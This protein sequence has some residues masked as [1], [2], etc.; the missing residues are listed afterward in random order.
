MRRISFGVLLIAFSTLV[1]EVMLTR[2]FDVTLAP[3]VSYFVVTLAVFSFGL[4]G[5]YATLRPIPVEQ[6]IRRILRTRSFAFAVT[7]LLLVPVI[8]ALPLDYTHLGHHPVSIL[9]AF[10]TLYVVLLLPFFLAGYILIAVFSKYAASIQR[11]YFWD[12]IGAGLGTVLVIPLIAKIGPGGLIVCAAAVALLAAALFSERRFW[13]QAAVVA[14]IVVAAIPFLRAPNYIDFDQHMDKRGVMTDL[15]AGLGEFVRWDPIAKI[16]VIDQ[17][18]T[19]QKAASWWPF[20]DRKVIQYDGG[21]QSSYFFPFDGD[22]KKFRAYIDHDKSHVKAHFWQIGVLASHYLKRDSG[23]SVLIIGSAGG[24]ETKAAL[25]Y[26]AA[27][28]DAVELVPTVVELAT[29]QYSHY[30]GDIFHNPAVHAVAG[31][32]RSYLRHSDRLYDIIQMY[33]N[34][35]NSS[36][37]QGTGA[38]SPEYLQTAEAY[39]EYFSHLTPNGVLHI[40]HSAF[41]RMI[42]TAALA[43]KRMG[44]TDFERHVAVYT[45]DAEPF[46][47]TMLIKMQPWT[48]AEI[49]DLNSFLAPPELGARYWQHLVENPLDPSKSFLSADF[50][51]GDFP[52][53]LAERMPVDATPSSDN[54]PYFGLMRKSFQILKPDPARFLDAGTAAYVNTSMMYDIVPMDVI[55]LFVTAAVSAI[56]VILF[57]FVPL[58]FSKIGRE[59]GATALPLLV[60]FSCLGAGFIILELVFIQKFMHLIGSPLYTYSTVIF[61]VL[62]SAGVGSASSEHLGIG[63]NRRWAVPFVAI[64]VIGGALVA[65]YPALSRLALALPLPGRMLASSLMM[66]PLGFFLGM[67]FPLGILAISNQPRGAI[68]WAWGM[69][70]LFTVVGGLL[71]VA[72]GVLLGFNFTILLALAIYA[73]AFSI[74]RRL[75]AMAPQTAGREVAPPRVHPTTA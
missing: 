47:P 55:H 36:V 58:R 9:S 41:P 42:S 37:A 75:R 6:D 59:E 70:G 24:Q 33:S 14:A 54:Q 57:V 16:N 35:T 15:K 52:S 65:L 43:W 69:N 38:L 66:F 21:N 62:F 61:T 19:P 17:K 64:L 13:T 20:G 12:L 71:S 60:Y 29:G 72:L 39:E 10:V 34:Y 25:V 26:G 50:Y 46:L 4:A 67:P 11:L 7:V 56:F 18:W 22:L 32:G 53:A 49:D 68:A 1:L 30:I 45:S 48:A 28:V 63:T 5:I 27:H 74:F 44:R 73:L 2:A 51:S 31:E 23:Q 40:N 3:N 8:N